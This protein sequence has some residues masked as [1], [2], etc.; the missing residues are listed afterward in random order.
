MTARISHICLVAAAGLTFLDE[1]TNTAVLL[2]KW[3]REVSNKKKSCSKHYPT[4]HLHTGR[5]VDDP[6]V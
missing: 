2:D 5:P 4:H 6:V 3:E 1:R